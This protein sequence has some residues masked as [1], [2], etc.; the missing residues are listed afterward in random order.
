[1]TDPLR[2]RHGQLFTWYY[3][4]NAELGTGSQVEVSII[5]Y[6][7]TIT[8]QQTK[9]QK[10]KAKKVLLPHLRARTFLL[11]DLSLRF[12]DMPGVHDG[13]SV[14]HDLQ[15]HKLELPRLRRVA[16]FWESVKGIA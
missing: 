9:I 4:I 6:G 1:M 13:K 10:E 11:L 12:S 8:K 7:S 5:Q 2:K 15:R 3:I 16:H 14:G